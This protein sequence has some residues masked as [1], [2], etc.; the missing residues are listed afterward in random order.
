MSTTAIQY[1]LEVIQLLTWQGFR[2]VPRCAS[3]FRGRSWQLF[4]GRK[5][6][7]LVVTACMG[8]ISNPLTI[9]YA[10]RQLIHGVQLEGTQI[11]I[12]TQVII[13]IFEVVVQ[14][15]V[16]II[17]TWH[18]TIDY[19]CTYM[20]YLYIFIVLCPMFY[21]IYTI[22]LFITQPPPIPDLNAP[23]PHAMQ[24]YYGLACIVCCAQR[25]LYNNRE[26][27][28]TRGNGQ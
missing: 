14:I 1:R 5:T 11:Q 2:N 28:P 8:L 9:L 15:N 16:Q 19:T 3:I 6:L 20:Q 10:T 17:F 26:C 4:A 7:P 18:A 21:Q 23:L 24:I 12:Y 13:I 22:Q 27:S 25:S